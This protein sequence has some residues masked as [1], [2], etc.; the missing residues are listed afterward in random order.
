MGEFFD[1]LLKKMRSTPHVGP[2]QVTN[3]TNK[4]ISS[5]GSSV[6][7][8]GKKSISKIDFS[9]LTKDIYSISK[10]KNSELQK[11]CL[12]FKT[13]LLQKFPNI[14]LQNPKKFTD[15][16]HW[17]KIYDTTILKAYCA[18]KIHVKDYCIDKTGTV[19]TIPILRI[20]DNPEQIEWDKLPNRFVI[21]CNHGSGMNITVKDKTTVNKADI[22][23]QL[24]KW[25][26]T[27][28]GDGHLYE[29]HY[30]LIK[31]K[32]LIEEYKENLEDIKIFCFNGTPKICQVDK[33]FQEHKMNFY[34]LNWNYINWLSNLSYPSNP[35]NLDKKPVKLHEMIEIAK[36]L[37]EDFKFVRVDL[38]QEN[39]NI[40]LGELT[41]IPGGGC[42]K[43]ANEGD[44]KLGQMLD[45]Q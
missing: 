8:S 27:T 7:N 30:N 24:T 9:K 18:D 29:L 3:T 25:L 14:N 16:L 17:L 41:F 4:T 44:L 39:G 21:K 38:Y 32:I 11:Y 19:M 34:D 20:Y 10:E 33:H 2:H 5:S 43:Y 23:Q 1:R 15:K 36:K 28:Y 35:H 40:Y 37:S 45:L 6:T 31:P 42:Q 13:K 12:T 26:L 22:R